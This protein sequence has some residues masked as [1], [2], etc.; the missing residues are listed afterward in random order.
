MTRFKYKVRL[1]YDFEMQDCGEVDK[2]YAE[3]EAIQHLEDDIV[4]SA[5]TPEEVW[6]ELIKVLKV[7]VT[8]KPLKME[9]ID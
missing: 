8:V 1:Y 7:K 5:Y 6:C 9:D 4:K 3:C 2:H